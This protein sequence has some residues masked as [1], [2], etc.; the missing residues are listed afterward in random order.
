MRSPNTL[1]KTIVTHVMTVTSD[2]MGANNMIENR[3]GGRTMRARTMAV[4]LVLG[5]ILLLATMPGYAA[6]DD[7]AWGGTLMSVR[8]WWQGLQ[9]QVRTDPVNRLALLAEFI[10]DEL[11]RPPGF[12]QRHTYQIRWMNRLS[13]MMGVAQREMERAQERMEQ[14]EEEYCERAEKVCQAVQAAA[15]RGKDTLEAM[16]PNCPEANREQLKAA[17]ASCERTRRQAAVTLEGIHRRD[18]DQVRQSHVAR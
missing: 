16:G 4:V 10:D 11:D 17:I 8:G 13:D 18:R 15:R 9:V 3:E 6:G 7:S 12:T 1:H 5:G 2:L 14:C